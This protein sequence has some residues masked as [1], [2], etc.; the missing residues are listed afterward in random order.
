MPEE[1]ICKKDHTEVLRIEQAYELVKVLTELGIDKVRLT[2]GEPLVRNG[3][4][5]LVEKIAALDAVNDFSITTNGIL[6]EKFAQPLKDAGLNR[7]NI[8]LDTLDAHKFREITRGGDLNAV[9]RGIE[10]ARNAGLVPIKL[11]VVMINGFNT[12]EVE[13]FIKMADETLEVRFI[14]LMPIGEAADWNHKRFIS[15]SHLIERYGYLLREE[16]Q[17]HTGPAKY[18]R[19]DDGKGRVGF[20]NPISE[21]F[22]SACNR[23]RVTPDGYLKTCLHSNEEIALKPYLDNPSKL[24][25][26]ILEAVAHKP[27]RHSIND[28]SFKP[29]SRS[30]HRIGG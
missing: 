2:G 6:L 10:A 23:I 8:S 21:H 22:C 7:V 15:N 26:K 25:E 1:G 19:R 24:K 9:L 17:V 27:N 14:E 18:F 13:T 29:I 5:T 3:I 20:I 12:D 11:N 4:M 16:D 28:A 30:M